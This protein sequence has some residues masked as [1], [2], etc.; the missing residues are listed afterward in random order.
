MKVL[1]QI[2]HAQK[3]RAFTRRLARGQRRKRLFELGHHHGVDRGIL[4]LDLPNRGFNQVARRDFAGLDKGGK[5]HHVPC[6]PFLACQHDQPSRTER[7]PPPATMLS[8]VAS[9]SPTEIRAWPMLAS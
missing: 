3:A 7:S 8:K 4:R 2:G 5:R 6:H 9:A 1:D